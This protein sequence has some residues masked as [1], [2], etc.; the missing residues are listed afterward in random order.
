MPFIVRQVQPTPNPNA[1]KFVVD[2]QITADRLSF[3][4][5]ATAQ[6]HSLASRLFAI[7]GVASLLLLD[8]FVTVSKDPKAKWGNITAKVKKVLASDGASPGE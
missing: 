3:L 1:I 2:R 4:D 7:D 8:D 6:G 5:S